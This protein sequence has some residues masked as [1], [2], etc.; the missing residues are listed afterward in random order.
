[1]RLETLDLCFYAVNVT[2]TNTPDA[3]VDKEYKLGEPDKLLDYSLPNMA[4]LN[5]AIDCGAY[6]INFYQTDKNQ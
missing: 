3:F 6:V 4:D 1:M 5:L 2:L